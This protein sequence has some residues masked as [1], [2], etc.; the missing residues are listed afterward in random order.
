MIKIEPLRNYGEFD[1]YLKNIRKFDWIV[2][3]SR[4]GA[5]YFFKRLT[6]V[7][8]DA[9]A[10]SGIKIAA[11]GNSTKNRLLASGIIADL[12]PKKESSEGLIEALK[13]LGVRGRE[14]FL[15]RSD[16]S[17]KNLKRGLEKLGAEVVESFAYKNVMPDDLPDL[18]LIFFDE[19]MFT[20]PSTVRNFKKRY[21]HVPKT[22]RIRCIGD[23]TLKE[24]QKWHLLG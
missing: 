21:K 5:E 19:I 15:P 3:A 13:E 14:I 11:V 9:R 6:I 23:V 22:V 17:D 2:F 24:A 8:L 12:V 1:D 7:G 20:S 18:D 16:I 10:L 4:Y